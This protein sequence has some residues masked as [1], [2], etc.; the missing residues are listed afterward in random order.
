MPENISSSVQLTR[1]GLV[2]KYLLSQDA[3]SLKEDGPSS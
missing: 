2:L 1:G 3:K